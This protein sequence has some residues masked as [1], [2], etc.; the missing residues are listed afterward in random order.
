MEIFETILFLS[1]FFN[2][3][4]SLFVYLKD[5]KKK[6]NQLFGV[7]G[8]ITGVWIFS[9]LMMG[10]RKS[11]FWLKSTYAFGALVPLS[12][13]F[14]IL[15]FCQKKIER[16]KMLLLSTLGIF[17]F[18]ISYFN[19][20][21]IVNVE[22]VYLGGFEGKTGSFFI[23]YWFYIGGILAIIFFTLFSQYFKSKGI[24]KFQIGYVILGSIFYGGTAIAVNIV[25]PLFGIYKF[26][27][28]DSPSSLLFLFFTTLAIT[29]Y[30]LFGIRIILT[31]ILVG[32]MGVILFLQ[33]IFAQ[34]LRWRISTLLNSLL[35]LIFAF[36]LL[37]SIHEEEKRREEAERLV[38]KERELTQMLEEKIK[39][40]TRELEESKTILEIKVAARTRELRELA[41]SLDQ[42]VK[43]KTKEL[44]EKVNELETSNRLMVGRELK[45]VEL[46]E[47]IK[48]LR[49]ELEKYKKR[50]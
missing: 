39:E 34:N 15:E 5:P 36:Y 1:I 10:I 17:F 44:Q 27:P 12:A 20:L 16:R 19:K 3:L 40:K 38:Q 11:L 50:N 45:M 13:L 22:K 8:L 24:R 7:S 2:F 46:K 33:I 23:F 42:Q 41:A 31:E 21:F 43:E 9:N 49:E 32:V 47:E 29:K 35:F 14:W 30:H 25:L 26:L 28:L 37:K 4:L 48:R 6:I 18:I